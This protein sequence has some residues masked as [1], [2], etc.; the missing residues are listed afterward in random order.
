MCKIIGARLAPI[1]CIAFSLLS[2]A[3]GAADTLFGHTDNAPVNGKKKLRPQKQ[4]REKQPKQYQYNRRQQYQPS[5]HS[6]PPL[7]QQQRRERVPAPNPGYRPAPGRISPPDST[8]G[9]TPGIMGFPSGSSKPHVT[10]GMRRDGMQPTPTYPSVYPTHRQRHDQPDTGYRPT[11]E[12]TLPPATIPSRPV[13]GIMGM[14]PGETRPT[15]TPGARKD[16]MQPSLPPSYPTRWQPHEQA[17]VPDRTVRP[18]PSRVPPPAPGVVTQPTDWQKGRAPG[19][20]RPTGIPGKRHPSVDIGQT[21]RTTPVYSLPPGRAFTP[22]KP[23]VLSRDEGNSVLHQ[24]NSARS[25]YGGIDARPIPS[26]RVVTRADGRLTVDDSRGRK[27]NLRPDGRLESITNRD[28]SAFFHSNGKL[29]SIRAGSIT[30]NRNLRDQREIITLRP[31]RSVLVSTGP[32]RGYL[33]RTVVRN[34]VTIVQRTYVVNNQTYYRAYRPHLYH[35]REFQV[36]LP[37]VYYAPAFYSWAC[38]TWSSPIRYAW[39]W[40]NDPWFGY[41]RGYF[42]PAEVYPAA[43]LWLT[44]YLLAETL[45][46]AYQN[47][48]QENAGEPYGDFRDQEERPM[49]Q[50]TKE[51]ISREV[52][53]Q[54]DQERQTASDSGYSSE[55]GAAP[56]T[57]FGTGQVFVVSAPLDVASDNGEECSLNSGDVL[58]LESAPAEGV[59]SVGLYVVSSRRSSCPANSM[60]TVA[61]NDLQEMNNDMRERLY[62]G[63]DTLRQNEGADGIPA[64]PEDAMSLPRF[65][66]AAGL[67]TDDENLVSMLQNQQSE[68]DQAEK[69]LLETA[70]NQ[71]QAPEEDTPHQQQN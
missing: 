25:R 32:R 16:G 18:V 10:P 12:R 45:R 29:R 1:L 56:K 9:P 50:E 43:S 60:V 36:F 35:G 34:R 71:D 19:G 40:R 51:M 46:A 5:P 20:P 4:E 3:D 28:R 59:E 26:G 67:T 47:Q 14:P 8:S 61:L 62:S 24:V 15:V 33:Q 30:I 52:Q 38:T 49:D 31:D 23:A 17:P 42:T 53:R 57:L 69:E 11:P 66:E 2:S 37:R 64:A 13:P 7:Y 65:S 48:A 63:L 68:A 44:D 58:R 55:G 27:F 22:G 21:R 39:G 41:Y 6:S 54:L 70:F